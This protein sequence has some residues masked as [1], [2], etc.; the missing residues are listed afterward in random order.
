[1]AEKK[2]RTSNEAAEDTHG[3]SEMDAVWA[4]A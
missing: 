1:M 4:S 3:I 2:Q